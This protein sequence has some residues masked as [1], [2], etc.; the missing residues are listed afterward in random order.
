MDFDNALSDSMVKR[1]ISFV[2][3]VIIVSVVAIPVVNALTD[4]NG[5]DGGDSETITYTNT[6][7]Y[8]YKSAT[9]DSNVH[10]IEVIIE[11]EFIE[12]GEISEKYSVITDG[13]NI[14]YQEAIDWNPYSF[15]PIV[16]LWGEGGFVSYM[17]QGQIAWYSNSTASSDESYA[18]APE[19][20]IEDNGKYTY[21]YN[22]IIQNGIFENKDVNTEEVKSQSVSYF[23]ASSGEYVLANTPVKVVE[24]TLIYVNSF[25]IMPEEEDG[26]DPYMIHLVGTFNSDELVEGAVSVSSD[27]DIFSMQYEYGLN[28]PEE[29]TKEYNINCTS[30]FDNSLCTIQSISGDVSLQSNA[31]Y[32]HAHYVK[33]IP[34]TQVFV[35]TTVTVEEEGGDSDSSSNMTNTIIKTI[36]IF[37]VLGLLVA[38][39]LPM[40]QGKFE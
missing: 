22:F 28:D 36:P 9:A 32:F 25:E 33:S 4:E 17:Y 30:S 20:V 6:G 13:V 5:S 8:Y 12:S 29:W 21:R 1:V 2:V 18:I 15:S 23:I 19:E 34:S 24:D 31:P 3:A 14:Y 35:P 26:A 39:A 10:E 37:L 40:V 7:E 27:F 11:S 16:L 38:F